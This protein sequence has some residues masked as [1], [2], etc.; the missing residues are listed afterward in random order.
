[1]KRSHLWHL[2]VERL[3]G[4]EIDLK[5][6]M[7]GASI[8]CIGWRKKKSGRELNRSRIAR[9]CI[10]VSGNG[11]N[12]ILRLWLREKTA[13]VGERRM[14]GTKKTKSNSEAEQY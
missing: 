2:R 13:A 10:L 12:E 1:M 4:T 14:R 3:Q 6:Y 8:I 7:D 11:Q 9:P 5:E